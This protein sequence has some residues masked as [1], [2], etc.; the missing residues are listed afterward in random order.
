MWLRTL[1]IITSSF[2][3]GA[4]LD[5]QKQK[6][7]QDLLFCRLIKP[8]DEMHDVQVWVILTYKPLNVIGG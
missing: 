3:S 5:G 8:E 4:D 6:F 7:S 2:F 1:H